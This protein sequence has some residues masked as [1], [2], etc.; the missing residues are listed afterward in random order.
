M[1]TEKEIQDRLK[2]IND[3]MDFHK[4][5]IDYCIKKDGVPELI[6]V[7]EYKSLEGKKSMLEWVMG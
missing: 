7:L 4:D 6:P 2:I 5:M 3:A 1:K